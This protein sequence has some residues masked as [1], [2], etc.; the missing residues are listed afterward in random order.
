M[1]G[2]VVH[3]DDELYLVKSDAVAHPVVVYKCDI[4]PLG[5]VKNLD[6]Q[7]G[8]SNGEHWSDGLHLDFDVHEIDGMTV[9]KNISVCLQWR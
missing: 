1:R 9:A 5:M 6:E 2:K 3:V 7:L 4:V 8:N